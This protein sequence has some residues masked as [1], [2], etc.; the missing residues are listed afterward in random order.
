MNAD[1]LFTETDRL[2]EDMEKIF[3]RM[4]RLYEEARSI[5]SD[6]H[7]DNP[8]EHR[9]RFRAESLGDRMRLTGK[10][11]GMGFAMFFKGVAFIKFQRKQPLK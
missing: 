11:L 4:D 9:I 6:V 10:F 8:N 2:F 3:E 5:K 1:R 7:I